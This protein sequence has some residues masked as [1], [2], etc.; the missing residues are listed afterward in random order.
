MRIN[1]E[2]KRSGSVS[3]LRGSSEFS[4]DKKEC[5]GR[6]LDSIQLHYVAESKWGFVGPTSLVANLILTFCRFL[7]LIMQ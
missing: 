7:N 6:V 1:R 2:Q 5:G 3:G 4:A